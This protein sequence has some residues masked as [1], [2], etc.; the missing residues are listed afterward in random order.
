MLKLEETNHS[1]YCE[2]WETERTMECIA[3]EVKQK[4]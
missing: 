4:Q 2:C 3:I 1:Y